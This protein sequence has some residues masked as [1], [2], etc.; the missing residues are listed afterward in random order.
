MSKR[1][2]PH[3]FTLIELLA[4][5]GVI[6]IL[7]AL[8][9]PAMRRARESAAKARCLSNLHQVAVYLQ[10]YQN[11]YRGQI[12]IYVTAAHMDRVVYHG[13]VNDYSN[14][15]LLVP[16]HIAPP[17]GSEMGRVFYCPGS[18]VWGTQRRFNYFDPTNLDASN[19]WIGRQG[20]STRI[21]YSLRMEYAAWDGGGNKVQYPNLRWEMDLSS[22]G[23]IEFKTRP[24]N[25]PIFPRAGDFN[26]K[27]A[28]ALVMDLSDIPSN[29]RLVHRGGVNVLYANWAAK[30]VPQ[31]YI[32]KHVKKLELQE[33][34]NPNGGAPVLRAY[35][36]MW[37]ELDR[38]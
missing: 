19:P 30:Y 34:A 22:S 25:T 11:Q 35:F 18:T 3:A 31:E 16:A 4:V 6:A 9:L 8:T 27:G 29:R 21:T 2:R 20:C 12:P 28:S 10:Q 33:A 5:I 36:D 26:R 15:G 13:V 17:N 37:Q 7:I 24:S 1:L 32:A 23:T 38:F 14:L